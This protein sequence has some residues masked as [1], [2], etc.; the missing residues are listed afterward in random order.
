MK[1]GMK[2]ALAAAASLAVLAG[3]EGATDL[4]DAST[5]SRTS[6]TSSTAS[7]T[8]SSTYEASE[9]DPVAPEKPKMWEEEATGGPGGIM[10][11]VLLREGINLPPGLADEYADAVCTDLEDGVDPMNIAFTA[12]K[13]LAMYDI[14]EHAKMVGASV[15][16]FC[17]EYGYMIEQMG[18]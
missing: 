17:P 4:G 16:A 7:S 1:H 18:E 10:E 11:T 9:P 6:T 2:I 14:I 15:G 12:H 5:T 8:A 3:C 13:H